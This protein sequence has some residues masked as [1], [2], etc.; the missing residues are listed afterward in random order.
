[1]LTNEEK[2]E[3]ER[4]LCSGSGY[5]AYEL[6]VRLGQRADLEKLLDHV[7]ARSIDE[8]V[9]G[10]LAVDFARNVAG[11]DV[12]GI[13]QFL[14]DI[15]DENSL[16]AFVSE[17]EDVDLAAIEAGV[18][19]KGLARVACHIAKSVPGANITALQDLVLR[20]SDPLAIF[21]FSRNVEGA[22]KEGATQALASIHPVKLAKA[23]KAIFETGGVPLPSKSFVFNDFDAFKAALMEFDLMLLRGACG[24]DIGGD[25]PIH[26]FNTTG[27][28]YDA[29]NTWLEHGSVICVP[30]ENVIGLSWTWPIA[31]SAEAGELHHIE[32]GK[33]EGVLGDAKFP[34]ESLQLAI[35][36]TAVCEAGK[37]DWIMEM[38]GEDSGVRFRGPGM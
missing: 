33:Y 36:L 15:A 7:C 32:S 11:A 1:M 9:D 24:T 4:V 27:D 38:Q 23:R 20:S 30:N 6:A 28:A 31:V 37:A 34:A 35:S 22:S 19:E 17:V 13:Q 18:I 12:A 10:Q 5:E 29:A 21:D 8:A 26:Y 25:T 16:C 14:L 2:A 3:Q